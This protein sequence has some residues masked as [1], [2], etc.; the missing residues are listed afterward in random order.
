MQSPTQIA[1]IKASIVSWTAILTKLDADF[2]N[3]A[4]VTV[5]RYQLDDGQGTLSARRHDLDMM[6]NTRAKIEGQLDALEARLHG[7]TVQVV[8]AW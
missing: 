1:R 3:L 5:E 6:L 4:D 2:L 7:G 8:P